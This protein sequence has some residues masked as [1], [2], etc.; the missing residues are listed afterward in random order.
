M[1]I[2]VFGVPGGNI[3]GQTPDGMGTLVAAN[4]I[5]ALPALVAGRTRPALVLRSE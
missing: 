3:G 2:D 4:L 1:K 5:A